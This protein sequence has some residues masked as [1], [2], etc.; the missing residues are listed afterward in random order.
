MRNSILLTGATGALGRTLLPLLLKKGYHVTCLVRGKSRRDAQHRVKALVGS[1]PALRV[2]R[3]DITE[4]RCGISDLDREHLLGNVGRILHCAASISFGD[5]VST[6]KANVDGVRN[7]LEVADLLSIPHFVHVSTAYVAG[8]E[9]SFAE[10]DFPSPVKYR[11]RNV[12]EETK[13]IGEAMVRAWAL[14]QEDRR[15]TVLRPSI[16]IG[17]EDGTSPTFDAYYG[18]FRPI[19]RVAEA[20]RTRFDAGKQLPDGVSVSNG[21]V[22]IPFVLHAAELSTLNLIPIDWAAEIMVGLLEAPMRNDTFHIVNPNPPL[23]RWVIETSLSHLRVRGVRVV[24]SKAEKETLL[25]A[26]PKMVRELQ[27]QIDMVVNMYGPYTSTSTDF[28]MQRTREALGDRYRDPRKLDYEFIGQ[29]LAYAQRT[30]WSQKVSV[31]A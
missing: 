12:Y 19:H 10:D 1:H 13:Q 5:K 20:M 28:E 2:I 31:L 11:P 23:V 21:A 6:H 29:L 4:P 8:G 17:F 26:Q 22:E 14:A 25:Q 9:P 27:R 15:F 30:E 3:G 24:A 7:I 16:L 18:Y